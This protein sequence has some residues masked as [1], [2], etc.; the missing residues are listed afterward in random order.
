MVRTRNVGKKNVE[1]MYCQKSVYGFEN[2]EMKLKDNI[3]FPDSNST[4]D[5]FR[6]TENKKHMCTLVPDGDEP[7]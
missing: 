2:P 7:E 6:N 1:I 4:H 5:G 3:S